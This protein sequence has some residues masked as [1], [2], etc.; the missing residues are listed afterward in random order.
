MSDIRLTD[1]DV[2]R[3]LEEGFKPATDAVAQPLDLDRRIEAMGV[4]SLR[5]SQIILAIEAR[6]GVTM[7]DEVL[8]ELGRSETIGDLRQALVAHYVTT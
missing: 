4:D 5:L 7:S 1:D 6:L 2:R 8:N 3:A